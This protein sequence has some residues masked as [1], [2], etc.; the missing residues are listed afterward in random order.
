MCLTTNKSK[1][2]LLADDK[3]VAVTATMLI[4]V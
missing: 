1:F 2:V 4:L 3:C